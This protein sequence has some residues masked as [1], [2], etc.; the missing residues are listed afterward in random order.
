MGDDT[1]DLFFTCLF[2]V[3]TLF[4]SLWTFQLKTDDPMVL[5]ID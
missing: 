4:I 1:I 2:L 3:Q 5:Q